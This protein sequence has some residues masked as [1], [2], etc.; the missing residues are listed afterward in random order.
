MTVEYPERGRW[1]VLDYDG[2]PLPGEWP[3]EEL[4][5]DRGLCG[6]YLL[7]GHEVVEY[8]ERRSER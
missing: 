1:V 5:I 6:K 7:S 2:N 4:A 3:T 8:P